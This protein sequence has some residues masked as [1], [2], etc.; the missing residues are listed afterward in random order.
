MTKTKKLC[1]DAVLGSDESTKCSALQ[2]NRATLPNMSR[3]YK[4][5][6]VPE[7]GNVTQQCTPFNDL[8]MNEPE[9]IIKVTNN[10]KEFLSVD[11]FVK[12]MCIY[13]TIPISKRRHSSS[14]TIATVFTTS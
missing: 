5:N 7:I 12:D 8:E 1:H 6:P 2:R 11:S 10:V 9:H 4:K 14:I 3:F 13:A